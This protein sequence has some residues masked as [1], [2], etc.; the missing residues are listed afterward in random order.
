M[1]NN[2]YSNRLVGKTVIC[3]AGEEIGRVKAVR[4]GYFQ[5]EPMASGCYWLSTAYIVHAPGE[6]VWISLPKDAL[7]DHRLAAPGLEPA[8]MAVAASESDRLLSDE[9]ALRQRER[10]EREILAQ[11]RGRFA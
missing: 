11:R 3:R 4:G 2:G 8:T 10:M 5:L 9:E 1:N 6:V 7:A